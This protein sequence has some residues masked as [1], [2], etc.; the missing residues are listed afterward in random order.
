MDDTEKRADPAVASM[1]EVADLDAP[2]CGN[3]SADMSAFD[4][5]EDMPPS[6]SSEISNPKRGRN[7][8]AKGPVDGTKVRILY[9]RMRAFLLFSMGVLGAFFYRGVR[10]MQISLLF[11]SC[12][13]RFFGAWCWGGRR[14]IFCAFADSLWTEPILRGYCPVPCHP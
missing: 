6:S 9:L 12:S 3:V 13:I 1:T 2:A 7:S 4:D 10:K 5:D 8:P 11:A 14:P